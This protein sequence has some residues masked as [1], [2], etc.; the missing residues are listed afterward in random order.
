MAVTPLIG[1]W[2]HHSR[3]HMGENINQVMFQVEIVEIR[4]LVAYDQCPNMTLL[5]S[6]MLLK[7]SRD[8]PSMTPG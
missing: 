4:A 8:S 3:M 6:K 7:P 5:D 2:W 1:V